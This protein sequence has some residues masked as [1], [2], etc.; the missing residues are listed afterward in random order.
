[1]ITGLRHIG[2]CVRSIDKTLELMKKTMNARELS[3][4][5]YP[6]RHQISAMVAIGDS[7]VR[8]EL[9][10]PLDGCGVVF[11]YI[12]K[13]GEGIHHVSLQSD[14]LDQDCEHF[15][16]NQVKIIGKTELSAFAHPKTTF[17]VLYEISDMPQI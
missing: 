7:P 2:F 9:M 11:D 1:M 10:E 5:A 13:H 17:G 16:N 14:G 8:F 4:K 6:D 15:A 12:E 3:R